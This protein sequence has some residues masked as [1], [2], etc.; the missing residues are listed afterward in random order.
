MNDKATDPPRGDPA[1]T[2]AGSDGG[3][4]H[5]GSRDMEL[6]FLDSRLSPETREL[7]AL[8]RALCRRRYMG[9]PDALYSPYG[10]NC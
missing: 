2:E 7:L 8:C 5:L 9:L 6:D 4:S 1:G 10:G 3:Y